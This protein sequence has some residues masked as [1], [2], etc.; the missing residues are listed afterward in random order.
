MS[1]RT[2]P[3]QSMLADFR[4]GD[5]EAA[6]HLARAIDA[7]NIKARTLGITEKQLK[8]RFTEE[9]AGLLATA[10]QNKDMTVRFDSHQRMVG[11]TAMGALMALLV[12]CFSYEHDKLRLRLDDIGLDLDEFWEL[13]ENYGL[14]KHP[15]LRLA[16]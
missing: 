1:A 5:L 11:S 7:G 15:A 2:L 8:Q 10:K 6:K 4:S 3:Y 9:A 16:C 12:E 14:T 13:T